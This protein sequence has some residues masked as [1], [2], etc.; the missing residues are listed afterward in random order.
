MNK[1]LDF[2][3]IINANNINN[4]IDFIKTILADRGRFTKSRLRNLASHPSVHFNTDFG[5][6][7]IVADFDLDGDI[8]DFD[9]LIAHINGDDIALDFGRKLFADDVLVI[10]V[11][12]RADLISLVT[13][14][15]DLHILSFV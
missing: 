12:T 6:D 7:D 4:V 13:T 1:N 15:D 3:A 5:I 14:I 11:T 9:T 10:R 2:D 8:D